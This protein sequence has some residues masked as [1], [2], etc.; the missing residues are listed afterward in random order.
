MPSITS[1]PIMV[2]LSLPSLPHTEL[3]QGLG[4]SAF[5]CLGDVIAKIFPLDSAVLCKIKNTHT[6]TEKG[7]ETLTPLHY[8]VLLRN[9]EYNRGSVFLVARG[10]PYA[11]SGKQDAIFALVNFLTG[12]RFQIS[13]RN[14][15]ASAVSLTYWKPAM[16]F[17]ILQQTS[18]NTYAMTEVRVWSG[19]KQLVLFATLLKCCA[20]DEC[21]HTA[22]PN[23]GTLSGVNRN[24][25][26]L[27]IK[28]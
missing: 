23:S 9:E 1:R 19:E 26:S 10:K 2:Q 12:L 24:P 27:L 20:L 22:S 16:W 13:L 18:W 28:M 25:P 7:R 3:C 5:L 6:H 4:I 17:V 14:T 8:T 21:E 15:R 11:P